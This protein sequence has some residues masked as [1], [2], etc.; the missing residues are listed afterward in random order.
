MEK[1]LVE[2]LASQLKLTRRQVV[3]AGVLKDEP[4]FP[5]ID[6]SVRASVNYRKAK[7]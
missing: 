1:R 7:K 5:A 4:F 6:E 3:E 2:S